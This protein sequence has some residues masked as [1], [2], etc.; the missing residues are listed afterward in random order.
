MDLELLAQIL[1]VAV[2]SGIICTQATQFVKE[3]GLTNKILLRIVSAI[4]SF[5]IGFLFGH[6]FTNLT[7]EYCLWVAGLSVIG[8][9]A[10]Y[11]SFEG[12]FGLKPISE[13]ES[14]KKNENEI[15]EDEEFE[16]PR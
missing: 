6:S 12:K 3:S 5:A 7:M 13:I 8:A 16:I 1:S 9:E 14:V 2:A 15:E 4:F 10:I 11:K